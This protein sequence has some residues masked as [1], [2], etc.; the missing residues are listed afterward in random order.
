MT[1]ENRR[2]GH[3]GNEK[4]SRTKAKQRNNVSS[5]VSWYVFIFYVYFILLLIITSRLIKTMMRKFQPPPLSTTTMTMTMYRLVQVTIGCS[6][7]GEEMRIKGPNDETEFRHL[8]PRL[9][10]HL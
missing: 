2:T 10:T 9:E 5:F 3:G 1:V 4:E 6:R 7:N 8:C